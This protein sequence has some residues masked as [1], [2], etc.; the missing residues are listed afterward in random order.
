MRFSTVKYR[1]LSSALVTAGLVLVYVGCV[2]SND[3]DSPAGN[4][5]GA[6]AGIASGTGG[7]TATGGSSAGGVSTSGA[8][9]C[10]NPTQALIH[11]FTYVPADGAAA[12]AGV[13][14]ITF[15]DFSATSLS[16]GTFIYPTSAITSDMSGSNWHITGTVGDYTG[17]G[18][19]FNNCAL[20]DASAYRGISF[21]I[22]GTINSPAP[23]TLTLGVSIA[24]DTI[25]TS[26]YQ[27]Y[28]EAGAATPNFGRCI[29]AS[30]NKYDGTCGDPQKA[31][32]ITST[33]TPV[34]I[35]WGDLIG[36]KPVASVNPAEITGVY[37][38][39]PWTGAGAASYT[40]DIII[41]DLSF[42]E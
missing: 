8:V 26:W 30:S 27:T 29:P 39:F 16:G 22:S 42:V 14:D 12:D 32:T 24:A 18:L 3:D 10:P 40:I 23:N 19:Y 34:T 9:A 28:P 33:P 4:A 20:I 21:T 38:F 1:V 7:G 2:S 11:S 31:I 17:M 41:D 35:L 6:T 15:G 5:T 25:A 37:W 36:G 13:S